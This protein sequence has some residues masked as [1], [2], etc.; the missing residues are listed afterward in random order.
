[1]DKEDFFWLSLE[2]MRLMHV[3]GV[4]GVKGQRI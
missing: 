2:S 3:S 1:M 4:N